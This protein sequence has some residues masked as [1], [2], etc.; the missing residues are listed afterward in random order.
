MNLKLLAWVVAPVVA[1][2]VLGWIVIG[3]I[4]EFAFYLVVGALAVGLALWGWNK[5]RG[6]RSARGQAR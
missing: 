6:T 4:T 1:L 2:I 5:L 3:L